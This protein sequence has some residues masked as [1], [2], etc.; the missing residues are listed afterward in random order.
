M[1]QTWMRTHI[2]FRMLC[3]SYNFSK[4]GFT[5]PLSLMT[6]FLLDPPQL[7]L[8][9]HGLHLLDASSILGWVWLPII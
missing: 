2:L 5:L 3:S 7:L 9:V 6:V 4:N 1:Q 8:Y